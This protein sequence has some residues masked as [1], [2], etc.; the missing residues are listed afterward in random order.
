MLNGQFKSVF[1]EPSPL[2][3]EQLSKPAMNHASPKVPQMDPIEITEEGV[4]NL[5]SGLNLNNTKLPDK[6]QPRVL[7]ECTDVLASLVTF[8]Y[9]A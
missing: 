9:K 3:L 1:T 2:Y 7:K 5:L 6:L 8:I 4:R